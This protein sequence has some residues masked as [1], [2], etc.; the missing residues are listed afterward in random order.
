[1]N[2]YKLGTPRY[3]SYFDDEVVDILKLKRFL[4]IFS[5]WVWHDTILN[6]SAV[7]E[8][9]Y[10]LNNPEELSNRLKG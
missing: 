4:W 10:L 1:M 8:V 9:V 5:I 3:S 7:D 6:H 2:Q